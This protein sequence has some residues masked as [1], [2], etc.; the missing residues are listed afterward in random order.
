M[1]YQ[2]LQD[3]AKTALRWKFIPMNTYVKKS[4]RSQI[5]N[6]MLHFKSLE[7]QEQAKLQISRLKEIRIRVEING[8][9]TKRTMPRVN[10]TKSWF[11]EKDK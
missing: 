7:K 1:T 11:F 8:K 2:N 5:N 4:D 9:E 10:E 3:I 6:L